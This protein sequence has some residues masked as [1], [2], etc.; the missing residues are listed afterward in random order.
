MDANLASIVED[1]GVTVSIKRLVVDGN[2]QTAP[3]ATAH[4]TSVKMYIE[5]ADASIAMAMGIPVG[6][7]FKGITKHYT[8]PT[9]IQMTD[10]VIAG[11]TTYSVAGIS[12][13]PSHLEL[14]LTTK[15]ADLT[16]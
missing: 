4:L 6:E 10:L 5:G 7:V 15:V 14:V 8:V 3:E 2:N 12:D 9:Q 11:S 16:S 13:Y 1:W